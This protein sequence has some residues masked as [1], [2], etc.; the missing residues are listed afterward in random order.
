MDASLL[1]SRR[2]VLPL[3]GLLFR[4]DFDDIAFFVYRF[5]LVIGFANLKFNGPVANGTNREPHLGRGAHNAV[6]LRRGRSR[7]KRCDIGKTP[8]AARTGKTASPNCRDR[9]Q[10]KCSPPDGPDA[11]HQSA[12]GPASGYSGQVE[13]WGDY[14]DYL[15]EQQ[16][17][18][19]GDLGGRRG[20]RRIRSNWC[21]ES[22]ARK[23]HLGH[24]NFATNDCRYV[25]PAGSSDLNC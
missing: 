21:P 13:A 24:G 1:F 14:R 10:W 16:G 6:E 12:R 8:R 23:V 19:P 25:H 11:Q 2:Q 22:G 9:C 4:G 17:P 15:Q 5:P 3:Q 7:A 18:L 20:H